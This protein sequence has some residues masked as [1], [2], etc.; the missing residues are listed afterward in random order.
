MQAYFDLWLWTMK[1][2][3]KVAGPLYLVGAVVLA[4]YGS[5]SRNS[6]HDA[7]LALADYEFPVLIGAS[8]DQRSYVIVPRVFYR[9]SMNVVNPL[10]PSGVERIETFA[11][12]VGYLVVLAASA[13]GTWWFWVRPRRMKRYVVPSV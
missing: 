9:P 10:A 2:L 1:G 13:W 6:D 4:V 7:A 11:G 8:G 5:L 12:F 3:L